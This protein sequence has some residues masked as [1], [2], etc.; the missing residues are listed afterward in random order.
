MNKT[1]AII[2]GPCSVDE[3][4]IS[5]LYQ[6]ANITAKNQKGKIKQAIFGARIVGLKSRTALHQNGVGMGI[7][8]LSVMKIWISL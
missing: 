6:I 1:C 4:N 2:A 7:D 3:N 5:E 8:Y